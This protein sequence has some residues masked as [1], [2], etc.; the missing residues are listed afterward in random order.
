MNSRVL[1]PKWCTPGH[2]TLGSRKN[3]VRLIIVSVYSGAAAAAAAP[4]H[5][6]HSVIITLF[7][8][9]LLTAGCWCR[10]QDTRLLQEIA[11]SC[12]PLYCTVLYCTVPGSG[13]TGH[14][15]SQWSRDQDVNGQNGNSKSLGTTSVWHIWWHFVHFYGITGRL[16]SFL[17]DRGPNKTQSRAGF[18]WSMA[19]NHWRI[20]HCK[21]P[22]QELI[23]IEFWLSW[24]N[25]PKI[26]ARK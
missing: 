2:W 4:P 18:Q 15:H 23:L 9:F 6:P 5:W 20:T 3:S 14:M 25:S 22:W 24:S 16:S 11:W 26:F 7:N 19:L 17:Q 12:V 13:H 1:N 10:G 21:I 8:Y